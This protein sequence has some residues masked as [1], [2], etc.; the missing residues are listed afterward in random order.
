MERAINM[1]TQQSFK[2]KNINNINTEDFSM[3]TLGSPAYLSD[4][5]VIE[6]EISL[7]L[8]K[9]FSLENS[10]N[11]PSHKKKMMLNKKHN[12][13]L[14]F[15]NKRKNEIRFQNSTG[16]KNRINVENEYDDLD[17]FHVKKNL[18]Q[19]GSTTCNLI[20]EEED[21][22]SELDYFLKQREGFKKHC[23][24]YIED[25]SK[26]PNFLSDDEINCIIKEKMKILDIYNVVVLKRGTDDINFR[27]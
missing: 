16:Q 2:L 1:E 23:E 9:S 24:D 19:S 6:N 22:Q 17:D 15:E 4:P 26:D 13:K 27:Y 21:D 11:I 10:E 12:L 8:G 3:N 5:N 18:N 25:E 7:I 20:I 14:N